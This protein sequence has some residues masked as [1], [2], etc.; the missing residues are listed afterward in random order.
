MTEKKRNE[1]T[2]GKVE[3]YLKLAKKYGASHFKKGDLE[4]HFAPTPY[5]PKSLGTDTTKEE[6]KITEED[7]LF[8]PYKGL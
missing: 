6:D 1:L 5:V 3:S 7:L 4:V 2:P 8:D